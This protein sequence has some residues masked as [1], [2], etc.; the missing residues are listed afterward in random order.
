MIFSIHRD[1]LLGPLQIVTGVVERRQTLSI[2][3]NLLVVVDE[4]GLSLTATDQE[5]ELSA[6]T[7]HVQ[8]EE[9]GKI[10]VPARKLLEICRRLPETAVVDFRTVGSRL[11]VESGRFK[12][13][14]ATLPA[15]S[16]P[17]VEMDAMDVGF[18]LRARV[19]H[20]LLARTIF[21][22]ARQD[23]RYHFNGLLIETM[24]DSV[25]FV[26]TNGQRLASSYM[27]N[28][29]TGTDK[30]Q[31]IVPRKG[32]GELFRL[33]P[34][35]DELDVDLRFSSNHMQVRC[36]EA[37]LTTKLIDATYPDYSLA[38]PENGDKVLV[39]NR[40]EIKEALIRTAIL[41]NE[42]YKNVRLHLE[43]GKLEMHSNNPLQEDA[44]ES[45]AVNYNGAPLKI[46]FNVSYLIDVLSVM[47]GEKVQLTF[48]DSNSACV[49]SSPDDI[50]SIYV[51]SA[52]ML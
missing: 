11:G 35:N 9:P 7:S 5:V 36:A 49:L 22:M 3:A 46:G 20:Q 26:A 41:S 51:I 40:Q 34:D 6:R 18:S 13:H 19:L 10:T 50:N 48:S 8:I 38:I 43:V 24:F 2:L 14:L 39:G 37:I 45:V 32:V 27:G 15:T 42:E 28:I 30:K 52:M 33:I 4:N 1:A 17:K 21:A 25:R 29:Q 47:G 44:E 31:F 12:S 23:I 16:F